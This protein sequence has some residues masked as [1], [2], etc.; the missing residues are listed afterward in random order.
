MSAT[1]VVLIS[2]ETGNVIVA[3]PVVR[4]AP[5]DTLIFSIINNDPAV[6]YFVSIDPA[7]IFQRQDITMATPPPSN[8]L[9]TAKHFKK[10]KPGEVDHLKH[11]LRPKGDF[12]RGN[13]QVPYTT[14]KYTINSGLTAT[15]PK[16]VKLDPDIDVVT[17]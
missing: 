15:D 9:Q 1:H 7:A 10:V 8:P 5:D 2:I 11:K 12:G 17:P 6:D 3:D 13:T 14:Y 4:V 16:P